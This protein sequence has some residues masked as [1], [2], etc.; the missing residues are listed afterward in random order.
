[1]FPNV[2]STEEPLPR[3]TFTGHLTK[4][5]QSKAKQNKTKQNKEE[6]T[7]IIPAV[8]T[9]GQ[10]LSR[11]FV[12]YWEL[13]RHLKIFMYSKCSRK[14]CGNVLQKSFWKQ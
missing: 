7:V 3:N 1:M 4:T 11:Y 8:P 9:S 10:K 6:A 12:R 13:L 14:I 2:S 5:K